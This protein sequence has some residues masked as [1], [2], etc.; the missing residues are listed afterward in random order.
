MLK[1]A[2]T[3]QVNRHFFYPVNDGEQSVEGQAD[4]MLQ[5]MPQGDMQIILIQ[6]KNPL[7]RKFVEQQV[8]KMKVD[9][10]EVVA[11]E[12]FKYRLVF[13]ARG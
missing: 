6:T 2:V 4:V 12:I 11:G 1:D 13:K 8:K 9:K 7:I 10:D 5:V 3:A